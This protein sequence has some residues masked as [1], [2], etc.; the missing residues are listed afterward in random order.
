MSSKLKSWLL[1]G[2]I[3]VVGAVSGS[4]LTFGLAPHFMHPFQPRSPEP[5]DMN[6][7]WK[8]HLTRELN[9]TTDQQAKIDPILDEAVSK[10]QALHHDEV[11]RGS[12]IFKEADD[13]ISAL[14]TPD[15]KVELQKMQSEREKM[16]SGH[17]HSWGSSGAP[18]GMHQPTPPLPPPGPAAPGAKQ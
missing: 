9:L 18:G 12:Q 14:L 15:Q 13:K 5:R 17:V 7:N 6:R 10:V 11:E 4:A 2:V 8:T 3:F 1:L 16:F